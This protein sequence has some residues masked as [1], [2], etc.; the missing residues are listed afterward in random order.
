VLPVPVRRLCRHI[1]PCLSLC[2]LLA[3]APA[4]HARNTK[5]IWG[6]AKNESDQPCPGCS[7]FPTYRQLGVD[8]YQFQI[9]WRDVAV[10]QPADPRNPADPAYHWPALY[11][12][13][14][15]ESAANGISLAAQVHGTPAWANGGRDNRWAPN[16]PHALGDFMYAA[17][18]RFPSIRRWMVWGEPGNAD[19]FQPQNAKRTPKIYA[20]MLDYAYVA[21]KQASR[22]NIVIGGMTHNGGRIKPPIFIRNMKLKSGRRPRM[23]LFGHNPFD[24]RFPRLKDKPIGKFRGLN[25]VDT[26]WKE[27][28]AAYKKQKKGRPK[29]LWL[30]E[31]TIQSDHNS[32]VF[33]FHVT[34]GEQA[35]RITAGYRLVRK[36]KYVD[37][38]G[39]FTLYDYPASAVNPAW[40]LITY[41]G[42]PKPAFA[43][44]AAVP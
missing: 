25:D 18:L 36:L 2:A 22:A 39:W 6:P 35:R 16:D 19:N 20:A 38:L 15:S 30:S 3:L 32:S 10:T 26:L 12:F 42:V 23:D 13:I 41:E 40:G 5:A 28:K 27:I 29:R 21:L 34:R 33:K 9:K 43:A 11:D 37:A 24:P 8:V 17:S 31:W 1:L 44:Y 14:V 7:L 4:A